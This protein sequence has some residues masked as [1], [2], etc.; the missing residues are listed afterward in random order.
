VATRFAKD[1]PNA[2]RCLAIL[3]NVPTRVIFDTMDADKARGNWHFIFHQVPH[4]PE[5]LISGR[6][7]R[8]LEYIFRT[9]CFDPDAIHPEELAAYI[10]AYKVT[11]ALQGAMSDYRAGKEDVAQDEQDVG[12]KISC[13]TLVL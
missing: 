11:G 7:G 2:I 8:W 5:M 12:V 1:Y 3:D 13:P 6:E 4:L 9:W 10:K